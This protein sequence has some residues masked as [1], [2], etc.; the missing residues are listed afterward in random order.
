MKFIEIQL[1]ARVTN[2]LMTCSIIAGKRRGTKTGR[3]QEGVRGTTFG[4][5][6][7]S[8]E[9]RYQIATGTRKGGKESGRR[10]RE[11]NKKEKEKIANMK[12]ATK[13]LYPS[14]KTSKIGFTFSLQE[15]HKAELEAMKK[16][17]AERTKDAIPT[18]D[19]NQ[20]FT[21]LKVILIP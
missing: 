1:H 2:T 3:G 18:A 5:G 14:Y 15:Q 13:K 11:G 12:M 4:E 8:S 17:E 16:A 7:S 10:N 21:T 6:K 19:M 9:G 20:I